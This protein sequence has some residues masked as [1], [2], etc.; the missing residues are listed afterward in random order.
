MTQSDALI[1]RELLPTDVSLHYFDLLRQLTQAPE[2]NGDEFETVLEDMIRQG[3]KIA[4]FVDEGKQRIAGSATLLVERKM[5]RGGARVGHIEDVVV[6]PDYQG[7]K[8]GFQLISHLCEVAKALGCYKVILDSDEANC[9]FYEKCGFFR[10][11]LQMR[12]D[13]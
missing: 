9:G 10:K 5:I 6:H 8:L 11:E 4:V 13:L 12:R 7:K 3:S 1:M 2:L